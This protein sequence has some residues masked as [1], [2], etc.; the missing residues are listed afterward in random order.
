[1]QSA[2]IKPIDTK[3]RPKREQQSN[4]SKHGTNRKGLISDS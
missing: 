1:M 2:D 4:P 3:E